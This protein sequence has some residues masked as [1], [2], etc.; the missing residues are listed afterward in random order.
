MIFFTIPI[1]MKQ[2]CH[3]TKREF[4]ITKEDLEF[5]EKIGVPSPT[6]CPE[7][8]ARR[9]MTW[10]NHRNLYYRTCD[11]TGKKIISNFSSEKKAKVYDINFWFSD[12]WTQLASG[13]DFDFSG[14][15][16]F[17]QQFNNLREEAPVPSLQ[18]SPEFDE[19]AEFTNYAGKNKNCYLIFDS[20][21]NRDGYHSCSINSCES[22]MDIFRGEKC[23]LCYELIDCTDCYDSMFLQDCNNCSESA[24]LKNCIGCKNCFGC[25][26][27]RNKEYYFFGKQYSKEEYGKKLQELSLEKR[28]KLS[29]VQKN[30]F[31]WAQQFPQKYIHGIQNE[32]VLGDYLTHSKNAKYC[33]DS[34]K[35]WD[36]KYIQ[37][38]FDDV[39]NSM[40]CTEVGDAAEWLYECDCMGYVAH[41]NRFCTHQL[42]KTV[43][44]TYC[45]FTPYCSDCFGCVGLHHKKFCIFNKQYSEEEYF[46]L[47]DKIIAYMKKT[48]EWGEFFPTE[49]S[50]F[51]Y[52]E[53]HAFEY[54]P[55]TKE[56]VKKRGWGW[57]KEEKQGKYTGEKYILPDTSADIPSDICEKIISCEECEKNYRL[58]EPEVEF[59]KK[60]NIP[61][62]H[63]C[64]NCRHNARMKLRNPRKLWTRTCAE[65]SKEIETTFAPERPEKVLC[66]ECYLSCVN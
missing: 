6:I 56:E 36:C 19:N 55:L 14:K 16:T 50:P 12:K 37:Q 65:C 62:P 27:L 13:K 38:G 8:R 54:L 28:S 63:K 23:E 26:N 52:N 43:N 17:F 25:V 41:S 22:V 21:K 51:C 32:D 3:I 60:M 64:P 15:T 58:V 42:G 20:D 1:P 45:Y 33:F 34:R 7:E 9:R 53:T 40:D 29:H 59:Y 10:A 57:K 11:G 49:I 2:I 48:G 35:L 46:I 66:E 44:L 18:R 61:I 4:E 31:E 39:R 30:F 24:F 47:K 5:Y